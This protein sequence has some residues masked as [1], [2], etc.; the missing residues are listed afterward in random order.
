MFPGI[1]KGGG[2]SEKCN[3]LESERGKYSPQYP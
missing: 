1:I 3:D 2:K